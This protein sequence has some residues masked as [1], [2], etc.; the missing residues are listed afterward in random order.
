MEDNLKISVIITTY[1]RPEL[2]QETVTSVLN[3]TYTNFELIIIDDCSDNETRDCIAKFD[4]KRIIY[5]RNAINMHLSASRNIGI[6]ISSGNYL[7]FLDDDDIWNE[8]KLKLQIDKFRM[9]ENNYGLVY[10]WMNIVSNSKIVDRLSPIANNNIFLDSLHGQPI[11]S[12]SSWMIRKSVIDAGIL[13]DVNINRGVDG[14]FLRQLAKKFYVDFIP[15]YLVDYSIH[16][17]KSRITSASKES[18]QRSLDG[19]LITE[20]KFYK[21]FI[22]NPKIYSIFLQRVL[23]EY[24]IIGKYLEVLKLLLKSLYLNPFALSRNTKVLIKVLIFPL[25]QKRY[26]LN[27]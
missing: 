25:L 20:K 6:D 8:N 16:H 12:A 3:Q 26:S 5:H 15:Q 18:I 14:D 11:S 2:L 13:F 10:T 27:D 4:D 23:F 19:N 21:D 22:A 17:G 24:L 9:I 7:C 1:N